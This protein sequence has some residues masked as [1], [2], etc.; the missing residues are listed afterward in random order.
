MSLKKIMLLLISVF[1]LSSGL[2]AEVLGVYETE[3][4]TGWLE[5]S[6][7]GYLILH[8]EGTYYDMG[9]QQGKLLRD[10]CE[11]T[12]G[13]M[14]G[15]IRHYL[16]I[17]SFKLV[18]MILYKVFYKKEESYIPSEFQAE[19]KG[20]ADATGS[21]LKDIQAL[22]SAI[23]FASCSG[24]AAFGP[25][26]KDGDLYQTRSLDY[27][28]GFID[29]K[30]KT[31]MHDLSLVVVY[32]PTH[33]IPYISFSW[34]G[35]LGSVGG[36]NAEGICVSEMT[37]V[38]KYE[39]AAGLP[40]IWRIK[41]TLA[42][43][44][45]LEEAVELMTQAP[46]EGGYNFL[47]GDGNIPKAVAIEM[48]AETA[49]VGSWDGPAESN[50]YE[51]KEKQ[52]QYEPLEGLVVRTNHPLSNALIQNHKGKLE[53]NSTSTAQRYRDLRARNEAEYGQIDLVRIMEIMRQHYRSRCQDDPDHEGCPQTVY[54]AAMAPESG[55]F[56][57]TSAHGN[58]YKIGV[59][60]ASAYNQP[61]HRFNLFDLV[62]REP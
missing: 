27:P 30:T 19:M 10:E 8:L 34:P 49:Y 52:Y 45:D 15:L 61:C 55:D 14:K 51:Y 60:D 3:T 33:G 28:L 20:L 2:H 29:P 62:E 57:I 17:A 44:T 16:P 46:L 1:I 22:H 13:S 50:T 38:S 9:Y 4:G 43:A 59:Y 7:S 47:V 32:K 6:E 26:T 23:F 37:D 39:S 54:Q 35:F 31:P 36:M 18:K 40:M 48:D 25:A 53:G 24:S 21:S 11:I 42:K 41:Q 56:I 5:R 58:Y 12:V